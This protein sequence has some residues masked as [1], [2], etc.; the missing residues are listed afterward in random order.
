MPS[1]RWDR[2]NGPKDGSQS[3]STTG[4]SS[5]GS[6]LTKSTHSQLTSPASPRKRKY[7]RHVARCYTLG[8]RLRSRRERWRLASTQ[9]RKHE[10]RGRNYPSSPGWGKRKEL[11][12][13]WLV[14]SPNWEDAPLGRW[15]TKTP[16]P[17]PTAKHERRAN[18]KA[19]EAS[20]EAALP[21]E[22]AR[23]LSDLHTIPRKKREG[24]PPAA[25]QRPKPAGG[26]RPKPPVGLP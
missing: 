10:R 6:R 20:Y 25:N 9:R 14:A 4:C 18:R 7:G 1:C 13:L 2:P 11:L 19:D 3:S 17:E 15:L 12:G 23:P 16:R 21:I 8:R 5:W 24:A 22:E 26:E